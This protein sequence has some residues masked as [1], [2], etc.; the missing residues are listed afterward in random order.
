MS[1]IDD[2]LNVI[3]KALEPDRCMTCIREATQRYGHSQFC[4]LCGERFIASRAF[5]VQS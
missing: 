5:V 3:D 1:K 4:N 2:I